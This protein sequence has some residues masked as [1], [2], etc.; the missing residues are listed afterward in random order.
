[1]PNPVETEEKLGGVN[2]E[3]LVLNQHDS[4]SQLK[5]RENTADEDESWYY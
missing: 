5:R 2:Q 4:Y 1:M 3:I